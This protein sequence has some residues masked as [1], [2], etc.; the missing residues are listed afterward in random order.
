MRKIDDGVFSIRDVVSHRRSEISDVCINKGHTLRDS[1]KTIYIT[2]GGKRIPCRNVWYCNLCGVTGGTE[3]NMLVS[4][5]DYRMLK[6]EG[7]VL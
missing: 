6:K 7:M 1:K 3:E 2:G 4:E 5:R